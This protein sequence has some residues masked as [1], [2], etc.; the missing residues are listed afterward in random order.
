MNITNRAGKSLQ[1]LHLHKEL[2]ELRKGEVVFPRKE[3]S[4]WMPSAKCS[5]L[6][7]YLQA[8]LYRIKY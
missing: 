1:G 6:K 5:A 8:A 3:H 2:Q 4:N 7:I